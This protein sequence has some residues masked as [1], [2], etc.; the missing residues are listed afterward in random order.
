[1]GV[2]TIGGEPLNETTKDE[3]VVA[4]GLDGVAAD[5]DAAEAARDE[6]QQA[7]T[8]ATINGAAQVA[9]A[10]TQANNAVAAA[11]SINSLFSEPFPVTDWSLTVP[12]TFATAGA[13][14][15]TYDQINLTIPNGERLLASTPIADL[16]LAVGDFVRIAF[17]RE[18]G[19]SQ[20]PSITFRA[21]TTLISTVNYVQTGQWWIAEAEIPAT[22]TIIRHDWT[23]STG[24]NVV[25]TRPAFAKRRSY[26]RLG[27]IDRMRLITLNADSGEV[28]NLFPSSVV[29]TRIAG[30]GDLGEVINNGTSVVIPADFQARIAG[31]DIIK[32]ND[33]EVTVLARVT[34]GAVRGFNARFVGAT[35]GTQV[36]TMQPIGDGWWRWSGV[37]SVSGSTSINEVRFEPDN[38]NATNP[39]FTSAPVTILRMSV[40]DGLEIP[41]RRPLPPAVGQAIY[42]DDEI[43]VNQITDGIRVSHKAGPNK[44][45]RW[46]VDRYNVPADRALGWRI[47]GM[48]SV[49]RTGDTSFGSAVP[50]AFTGQHET[51]IREDGKSDFMGGSVHGDQEETRPLTMLIDGKPVVPDGVT[52]YRAKQVEL[53]ERSELLEVDNPTRT[54]TALLTTRWLWRN[55]ELILDQ[56][57]EWV[58]SINVLACYLGM[59]SLLRDG[60]TNEARVSP[61][62]GAVDTSSIPHASPQGNFQRLTA[63]GPLGGFDMEAIKGWNTFAG[64]PSRALVQDAVA[65]NKMYFAP[66]RF[67]PATSVTAGSAIE[68]ATRYRVGLT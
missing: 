21:G 46:P 14:A 27:H 5:K 55:N 38:R 42:A 29:V 58:R 45:V 63:S 67:T 4:L 9:L 60:V 59:W 30:T 11:A 39:P 12:I 32:N 33:A 34:G 17:R 47:R 54:V 15:I 16:G 6:A 40:T 52:S 36:V 68:F 56:H 49:V 25:I 23:N 50:L 31:F 35:T 2:F 51:A 18:A 66:F 3:I 44:Y 41:A 1:M 57:L 65:G 28:A 22:T 48:E 24:S 37:I 7:A 8:D 61:V 19:S 43:V 64:N 20:P 13:G 26:A 10:T 53:I 62:Y